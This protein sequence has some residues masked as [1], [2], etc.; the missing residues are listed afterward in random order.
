MAIVREFLPEHEN[1]ILA[2][3]SPQEQAEVF[4]R[5]FE[6]RY[7][8]LEECYFEVIE[9]YSDFTH[10]I[11]VPIGG[12]SYEEYEDLPSQDYRAGLQLMA[13]LLESLLEGDGLRVALAEACV[14]HVPR[15]LLER[16]PQEGLKLEEVRRLVSD[17]PYVGLMHWANILNHDTGTYFFDVD[18][19]EVGYYSIEWD[20]ETV[21]DLT[22]QWARSELIQQELY[23]FCDWLEED[24]PA[25]FGELL[26]F[27][28]RRRIESSAGEG[29][30]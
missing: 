15:E 2:Q 24:L 3:S 21:E 13:Y 7:F 19:E 18:Y 12:I 9:E 30:R 20:R 14:E 16:V 27:I 1:E 6:D 4:A 22:R 17:T 5:R 11:P 29:E 26:D 23:R 25:H 10:Q 8:P 28:E